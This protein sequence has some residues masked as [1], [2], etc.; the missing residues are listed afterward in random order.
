MDPA[1]K[2]ILNSLRCPICDAQIDTTS[3]YVRDYNY[4]CATDVDHYVIYMIL[5]EPVIRIAS[6][7]V[8]IYDKNKKYSLIKSYDNGKTTTIIE[9]YETDLENRV[10]FSFKEKKLVMDKDLFDFANF[11]VDKALNRIKTVLV[12]Q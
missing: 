5:W 7:R 2:K 1:A 11:N 6:E 9:I 12:F 8:S 3:Y 10:I 4:G